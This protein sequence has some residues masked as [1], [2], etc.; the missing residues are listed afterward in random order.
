MVVF[1]RPA[2]HLRR[3]HWKIPLLCAL[4]LHGIIFCGSLYAPDI[5]KA[6][7][8]FAEIQTVSLVSIPSPV[9][10]VPER[11]NPVSTPKTSPRVVE[12]KVAPA[13]KKAPIAEKPQQVT[14][15]EA[16][17]PKMISLNPK[18]KK[19]KKKHTIE[20]D[21]AIVKAQKQE[22]V[23]RERAKKRARE[24]ARKI[25]QEAQLEEQAQL[26][27]AKARLAQQALEEERALLRPAAK[28]P[29]VTQQ[30]GLPGDSGQT[31]G[32]ITANSSSI[33][34]NQYFATVTGVIQSHWA[35][36]PN[37]EKRTDLQAT[38][39]V[40]VN[41]DGR[42]IDMFF[43]KHS[44]DRIFDQFVQ[45]SLDASNPLPP[46]PPAMGKQRIEFGFKFSPRGVL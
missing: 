22:K 12:K 14:A 1:A 31:T 19:I 30:S 15:P 21:P 41:Q 33:I 6:K 10:T 13:K 44:G 42:I 2:D 9:P 46:I 25:Q 40:T 28:T 32:Q 29:P 7:P 4:S 27:E 39:V 17:E 18:K 26:A 23:D 45:R 3:V 34:E 43:E 11:E 16:A 35:V 37:L 5:F 38:V 8:K 36:P 24:L 20:P